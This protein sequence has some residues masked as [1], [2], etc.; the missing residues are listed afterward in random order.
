MKQNPNRI[1]S[2][3]A[4]AAMMFSAVP[5]MTAFA[6]DAGGTCGESLTWTLDSSGVL[7]V[8]GTGRMA[9]WSSKNEV[10]W[11][12]SRAEISKAVLEEGVTNI[13][14]YAF[15]ECTNLADIQIPDGEM[16]RAQGDHAA[17]ERRVGQRLG[18]LR[19]CGAAKPHDP[20]L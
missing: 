10:P 9:E 12:R 16:F 13:G 2:I 3:F 7:T 18:V 11:Y 8:S 15:Y 4:A 1:L 20:E 14:G 17:V 19:M 5:Q 6:A